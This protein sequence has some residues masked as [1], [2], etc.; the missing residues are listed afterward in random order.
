[1]ILGVVVTY[2]KH[3]IG[4]FVVGTNKLQ[5]LDFCIMQTR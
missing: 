3:E 2:V 4:F 5:D 1:M